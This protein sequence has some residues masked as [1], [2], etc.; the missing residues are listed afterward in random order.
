MSTDPRQV[1]LVDDSTTM[2]QFISATLEAE[3]DFYVTQAP[4][5]FEALKLLPRSRFDLIITDINMPDINGLELLRFIR[6]SP[7]HAKVPVFLISTDSSERDRERGMKLG[8]DAYL[9]KPIAA[10]A[11]L[12]I[13]RRSVKTA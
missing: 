1:L 9:V 12:E 11:L 10:E 5:G 8:A 2:R 4:T 3:G 6:E 7:H 13:A